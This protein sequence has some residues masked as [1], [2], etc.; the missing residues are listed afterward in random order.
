VSADTRALVEY[1]LETDPELAN[2]AERSVAMDL[3]DDIPVPLTREDRM[4]AYREARR[5]VLLRTVVLA[6]VIAF[7]CVALLGMTTLAVFFLSPS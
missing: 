5:K 4:E 2:I 3:P 6:V 1:Y 7:I